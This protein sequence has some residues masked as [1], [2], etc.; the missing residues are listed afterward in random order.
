MVLFWTWWPDGG[1]IGDDAA[2][3]IGLDVSG[4]AFRDVLFTWYGGRECDGGVAG[5]GRD[6]QLVPLA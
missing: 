3:Y 6:F 2:Y 4:P 1:I 5:E